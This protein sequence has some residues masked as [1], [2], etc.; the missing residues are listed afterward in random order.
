MDCVDG[1]LLGVRFG[2]YASVF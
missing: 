1:F 2:M